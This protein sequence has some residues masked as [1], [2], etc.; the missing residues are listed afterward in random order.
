MNNYFSTHLFQILDNKNRKDNNTKWET[1]MLCNHDLSCRP[2][3]FFSA[4]INL[5]MIF[6]SCPPGFGL[7]V[8]IAASVLL[9]CFPKIG[10][11]KMPKNKT[12]PYRCVPTCWHACPG[13]SCSD[14]TRPNGPQTSC[15]G[16]SLSKNIKCVY[17]LKRCS[18]LNPV[19]RSGSQVSSG[20]Q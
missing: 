3:L 16:D 14:R 6:L 12:F 4:F 17:P 5:A 18:Q 7:L 9:L 20:P 13:Q 2:W 11:W 8:F 1:P 15:S 19:L 10:F